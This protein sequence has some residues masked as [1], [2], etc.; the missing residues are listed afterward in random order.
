MNNDQK[1][2][3]QHKACLLC[4]LAFLLG[5]FLASVGCKNTRQAVR[6]QP[7]IDAQLDIE[8]QPPVIDLGTQPLEETCK[9]CG[10]SPWSDSWCEYH[11]GT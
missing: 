1:I 8:L 7:P 3:K 4:I 6:V 11:Y 9:D 10:F 5:C 2:D